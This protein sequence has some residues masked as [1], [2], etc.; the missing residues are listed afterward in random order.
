MDMTPE[1]LK[2]I[3][4]RWYVVG[5]IYEYGNI[6]TSKIVIYDVGRIRLCEDEDLEMPT[7]TINESFDIYNLLPSDWT[8]HFNPDKVVSLYLNTTDRFLED[9]P[10]CSIQEIVEQKTM[11]HDTKCMSNLM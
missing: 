1:Q 8:E 10:F 3:N 6:E 9:T 2:L 7:Y 4:G 5:N 11:H